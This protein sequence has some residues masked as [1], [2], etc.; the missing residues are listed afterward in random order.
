MARRTRIENSRNA[1]RTQALMLYDESDALFLV[2]GKA[3]RLDIRG[4]PNTRGVDLT[5]A[6]YSDQA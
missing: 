2:T 6:D 1:K 3:P 4:F 5:C